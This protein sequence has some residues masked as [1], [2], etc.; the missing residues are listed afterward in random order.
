MNL[1]ADTR[2]LEIDLDVS[3]R[4]DL[5]ASRAAGDLFTSST[6]RA[7]GQKSIAGD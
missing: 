2:L 3:R 4:T 6:G 7:N 5:L 1:A